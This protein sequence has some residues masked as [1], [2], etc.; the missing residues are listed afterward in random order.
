VGETRV[1]SAQVTI[2]APAP[3]VGGRHAG[4][5]G[6]RAHPRLAL[7]VLAVLVICFAGFAVSRM[8]PAQPYGLA[9]D[10]RVFYAAAVVVHHGG[11]PYDAATIH[12]AEQSVDHYAAVQ[13]ALDNFAN[14]PVV[15]W[16]LQPLTL[17]PFWVSYALAAALGTLAAGIAM[18]HWLRRWGW[19]RART[20]T[21][22]AVLSWPALLAIFS[23]QFD[24][25]LLALLLG[26]MTLYLRRRPGLAG[27]VC[28][29]AMLI[30]PHIL[31]PLPLLLVASQLPDRRAAIRC[32]LAAAAT[33]L[34][35]VGGAELLMPG[36][37]G[38][39]LAHLLAFGGQIASAQPDLSGL[40]GMV[41]HL[42]GGSAIAATVTGLGTVAILG[43]AGFWAVSARARSLVPDMRVALGVGIGMAIWLVA[44]PYG[45]PNDDVLLF[46]LIALLV[47][48]DASGT[49]QRDVAWALAASIVLIAG[50]VVSAALGSILVIA[51]AAAV[52]RRWPDV[53]QAGLAAGSLVAIAILPMIWP[54]HVLPV[55]LTPLAALT[56][57]AGG[58]TLG[59]RA[60]QVRGGYS[61]ACA[62]AG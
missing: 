3:D 24:L 4:R 11:N 17:L 53:G 36:A 57:A 55:S 30:K 12:A 28:T 16:A 27:A 13:P 48:A 1:V 5:S 39:F 22:L 33:A 61:R 44:T 6:L 9:D 56:V 40:P 2:L 58:V 38:I 45:H 59:Y 41:E 32:A 15:A 23:G 18:Y 19:Q 10:W 52:W 14:L 26:G 20:W 62:G 54:F 37:T 50:F 31:W 47:G 8:F 34:G 51:V 46:P 42:P 21:V 25:L 49:R 35:M 60:L 43:F 7:G 29:A